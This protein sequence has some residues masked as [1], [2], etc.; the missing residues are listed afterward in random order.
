MNFSEEVGPFL[1]DDTAEEVGADPRF[2]KDAVNQE[3]APGGLFH[4][5]ECNGVVWLICSV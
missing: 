5:M 3:V 2:I 1:L 4:P